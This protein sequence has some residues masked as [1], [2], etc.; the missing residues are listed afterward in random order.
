VETLSPSERE[1]ILHWGEMS[2]RWSINRSMAQ[3]HALL[4]LSKRPLNAEQIAERLNLARS[5]VSTSLRELQAW[6][7][8]RIVHQLGVRRDYFQAEGDVWEMFLTIL[9]QRKR[10]EIDPTVEMLR[11]CIAEHAETHGK[12][13]FAIQRMRELLDLLQML[14]TWYTRM[15]RLSPTSQRMVLKMK[16]KLSRLS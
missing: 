1:F 13:A 9:D 5:N 3:I 12:D 16:D 6:G 14:E 2:S 7:I 4:Y 8:V 10:R 11:G 15:R